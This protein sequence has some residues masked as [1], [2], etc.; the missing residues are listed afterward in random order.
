M[1]KSSYNRLIDSWESGKQART[2]APGVYRELDLRNCF[3][4]GAFASQ[5]KVA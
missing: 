3:N 4:S 1:R 5:Q 2:I